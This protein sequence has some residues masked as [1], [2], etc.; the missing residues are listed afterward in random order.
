VIAD[1][2]SHG[3]STGEL[4]PQNADL[5]AAA[6]VGAIGESLVGPLA[7]GTEAPGTVTTLIE[8][9]HRAVGGSK[10]AHA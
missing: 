6:L 5:V 4:P 8:F 2:I 3:V 7:A 10:H 1:A 9:T